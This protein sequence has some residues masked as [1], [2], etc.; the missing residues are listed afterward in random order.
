LPSFSTLVW[1]TLSTSSSVDSS[2]K[3]PTM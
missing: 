1:I 2:L 3:H